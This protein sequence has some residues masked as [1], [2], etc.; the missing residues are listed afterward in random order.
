MKP[1]RPFVR[2]VSH[3]TRARVP[4]TACAERDVAAIPSELGAWARAIDAL[5]DDR[6]LTD[7]EA[8][9]RVEQHLAIVRGAPCPELAFDPV[10]NALRAIFERLRAR[11]DERALTRWT[12]CVSA[13]LAAR[14]EARVALAA[15]SPSLSRFAGEGRGEG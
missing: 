12:S 9:L 7:D 13:F 2:A 14:L 4:V 3:R 10:A 5:L 6:A 1:H 15:L 8:R 11:R